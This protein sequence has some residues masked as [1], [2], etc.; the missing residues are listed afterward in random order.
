MAE[1]N[2][3]EVEELTALVSLNRPGLEKKCLEYIKR[4]KWKWIEF[5]NLMPK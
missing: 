4:G 1:R 5:L 2:D 3:R